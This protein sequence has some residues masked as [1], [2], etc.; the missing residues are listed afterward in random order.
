MRET[1]SSL[2]SLGLVCLAVGFTPKTG[3]SQEKRLFG[4]T[5]DGK[6]V[7]EYTLKKPKMIVKL[8]YF[9]ASVI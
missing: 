7:H 8:I 9:V 1:F 5:S 6:N 3:P 2:L 4:T